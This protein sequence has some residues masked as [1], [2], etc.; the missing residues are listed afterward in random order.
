MGICGF[1]HHAGLKDWEIIIGGE[2]PE[3]TGQAEVAEGDIYF[4]VIAYLFWWGLYWL[5]ISEQ[6]RGED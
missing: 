5:V 2:E 6:R 4:L 1:V 3:L